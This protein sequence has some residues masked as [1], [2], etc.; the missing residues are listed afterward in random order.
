MAPPS[1]ITIPR[2]LRQRIL[3]YAF[4]DMMEE[5]LKFNSDVRYISG[6]L[7]MEEGSKYLTAATKHFVIESEKSFA[8][9]TNNLAS[10]L[11]TALPDIVDDVMYVLDKTLADFEEENEMFFLITLNQGWPETLSGWREMKSN[12]DDFERRAQLEE[13]SMSKKQKV[14]VTY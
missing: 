11:A 14:I 6:M 12:H 13:L 5:D 9:H 4:D 8:V 10:S 2:E 7:Y 3:A 1:L